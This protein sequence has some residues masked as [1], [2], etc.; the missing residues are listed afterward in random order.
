MQVSNEQFERIREKGR[1]RLSTLA[2]PKKPKIEWWTN[3]GPYVMWGTQDMLT[4]VPESAKHAIATER[5]EALSVPKRDFQNESEKFHCSL[6]LYSCGRPSV[7]WQ[8]SP[9]AKVTSPTER[10]EQLAKAKGVSEDYKENNKQ[11]LYSCGRASSVWLV[12]EAAKKCPERERTEQLAAPKGTHQNFQLLRDVHTIV[13]P[14]ALKTKPTERLETLA[15]PKQRPEGPFRE[16][17]WSVTQAAKNASASARCMELARPKGVVDG[18]LMA[19]DVEWPVSR[20]AKRAATTDRIE[21]IAKPIMRTAMGLVQFNPDAFMVPPSAL[22]CI[23]SKRIE[24]L[25][26]PIQRG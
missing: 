8:V 5:L 14:A 20:A 19:R 12:D 13:A 7:I 17:T 21:E 22:K 25:A 9:K 26:M 6:F 11:F 18:Y 2:E 24:E 10:L 16:P 3:V 15:S 1:N 4:Q 23:P